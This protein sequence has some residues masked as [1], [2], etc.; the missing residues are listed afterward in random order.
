LNGARKKLKGT[1]QYLFSFGEESRIGGVIM[2]K[3]FNEPTYKELS[4][5]TFHLI[6]V[7]EATDMPD[8]S[9]KLIRKELLNIGNA[10]KRLDPDYKEGV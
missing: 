5:R 9:F 2:E 7:V 10:I 8:R 4:D 1:K 6:S 3:S